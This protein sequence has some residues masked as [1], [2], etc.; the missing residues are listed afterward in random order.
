[1]S[2]GK[3]ESVTE[4]AKTE[5][6]I[7]E[8]FKTIDEVFKDNYNSYSVTRSF[9][10]KELEQQVEGYWNYYEKHE[11]ARQELEEIIMEWEADFL[12]EGTYVVGEDIPE[13]YYVFCNPKG[14]FNDD[15]NAWDP[16]L[17]E[18]EKENWL[19]PHFSVYKFEDGER[20]RVKGTPKFASLDRFPVFEAAED[21]N[22]YEGFYRIGT[23]IPEG[24]YF[25]LSMDIE[26]GTYEFC[27][28][29][30]YTYAH[31][32]WD[33][34]IGSRFTYICLEQE[35]EYIDMS[36]CVLIP[37]KQK[38]KIM[39]IYHVDLSIPYK[40]KTWFEI[41]FLHPEETGIKGNN[42]AQPVYAEGDYIIGE[43]IP[44]GS[45]KIEEEVTEDGGVSYQKEGHPELI[46]KRDLEKSCAWSGVCILNENEALQCGWQSVRVHSTLVEIKDAKENAEYK[47]LTRENSIPTVTFEE[48]DKGCVVRVTRAVLVPE[49]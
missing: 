32:P 6:E 30:Q 48:R 9:Y 1:M 21:E 24:K 42:Y 4:E 11:E 34:Y 12:T 19:S 7:E 15:N 31:S 36:N 47:D 3:K 46:R 10:I 13:G 2:C 40:K 38:P 28:K 26:N 14:H 44:F 41:F 27:T 5:G 49:R 43:D 25:M 18:T 8:L 39:P 23:D 20:F 45:Y 16:I 29:R 22:Y 33:R 37:I 17:S 35:D